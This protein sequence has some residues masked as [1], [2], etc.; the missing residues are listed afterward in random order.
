MFICWGI[1]A[2]G[3]WFVVLLLAI[4]MAGALSGAS[5]S[6]VLTDAAGKPVTDATIQLHPIFAGRD[7]TATTAHNGKFA[8]AELPA[9]SYQVSVR[10]TDQAWKAP[11]PVVIEKDAMLTMALQ[12]PGQGQELHVV[13][14]D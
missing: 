3:L 11:A 2:R 14:A 6:G 4:P 5:W 12:L 8:F 13:V 7:F 9:G 10:T 1:R